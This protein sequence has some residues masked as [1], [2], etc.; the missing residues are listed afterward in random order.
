MFLA[1]DG[2]DGSGKS[3]AAAA[4]AQ[5]LSD[6]GLD[7]EVREHPGKGVLGRTCKKLLLCRGK[8]PIVLAAVFLTA[9][10][11]ITGLAVRRS[12]PN[13]VVIAVRY[14]LS[15]YFLSPRPAGVMHAMFEAFMPMP[16]VDVMIDVE[17]S[18]AL[19]RIS[20]RGER[21]EAFENLES[22]EY[23]RAAM[24]SAPGISVVDGNGS[25]EDTVSSILSLV[26]AVLRW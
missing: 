16:D 8:T 5:T 6:R 17:P 13:K 26:D 3:S 18:V 15:S 23:T 20:A 14:D 7:V 11:M 2:L 22:M 1:I 4:I 9:D 25:R 12:G 24:L 19:Q 10:M 21:E